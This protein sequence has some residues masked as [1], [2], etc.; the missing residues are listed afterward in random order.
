MAKADTS[1]RDQRQDAA[2]QAILKDL[3]KQRLAELAEA[4]F[5]ISIGGAAYNR[6]LQSLGEA[7]EMG[8]VDVEALLRDPKLM[9]DFSTVHIAAG[10]EEM[11]RNWLRAQLRKGVFKQSPESASEL[12]GRMGRSLWTEGKY[13]L[14][15]MGRGVLPVSPQEMRELRQKLFLGRKQVHEWKEVITTVTSLD[16]TDTATWDAIESLRDHDDRQEEAA[17]ALNNRIRYLKPPNMPEGLWHELLKGKAGQLFELMEDPFELLTEEDKTNLRLQ[18]RAAQEWGTALKVAEGTSPGGM[19]P[20]LQ[21]YSEQQQRLSRME[22]GPGRGHGPLLPG[23]MSFNPAISTRPSVRASQFIPEYYNALR[24]RGITE[25]WRNNVDPEFLKKLQFVHWTQDPEQIADAMSGKPD[26][27]GGGWDAEVPYGARLEDDI[28]AH[29]YLKKSPEGFGGPRFQSSI[30]AVGL[31]LEGDV[32]FIGNFD[33]YSAPT[34]TDVEFEG[35]DPEKHHPALQPATSRKT[36]I[37]MGQRRWVSTHPTSAEQFGHSPVLPVLDK[38]TFLTTEQKEGEVGGKKASSAGK[39]NEALLGNSEVVGVVIPHEEIRKYYDQ[40]FSQ[41]GVAR[42]M[43][44]EA[45]K[46]AERFDVPLLGLDKKPLPL[47]EEW[48][49]T[50][51]PTDKLASKLVKVLRR[52]LWQPKH[53]LGSD[54]APLKEIEEALKVAHLQQDYQAVASFVKGETISPRAN[55]ALKA[56]RIAILDSP[57][58]RGSWKM[59]LREHEDYFRERKVYFPDYWDGEQ[60]ANHLQELLERDGDKALFQ[61]D[62][63]E[64]VDRP[65]WLKKESANR[66]LYGFLKNLQ[67]LRNEVE[68]PKHPDRGYGSLIAMDNSIEDVQNLEAVAA[69]TSRPWKD[70]QREIL[71]TYEGALFVKDNFRGHAYRVAAPWRMPKL[72]HLDEAFQKSVPAIEQHGPIV[73]GIQQYWSKRDNDIKY[74]ADKIGSKPTGLVKQAPAKVV[75]QT[76]AAPPIPRA[77]AALPA[78]EPTALITK[79]VATPKKGAVLEL[80]ETSRGSPLHRAAQLGTPTQGDALR[81]A[82]RGAKIAGATAKT[83]ARW[84]PAALQAAILGY[85][86][87]EVVAEKDPVKRTQLLAGIAPWF[88]PVAGTLGPTLVGQEFTK[89]VPAGPLAMMQMRT[90]GEGSDLTQDRAPT[91]AAP[92]YREG[93]L[94][95]RAQQK[96]RK[97]ADAAIQEITE[98]IQTQAP[99]EDAVEFFEQE[100]QQPIQS[101]WGYLGASDPLHKQRQDAIRKAMAKE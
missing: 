101:G 38:E 63:K 16:A 47:V 78:P 99:D 26:F 74:I 28:S 37:P 80:Y 17:K 88:A 25:A 86:G 81:T 96:K 70:R 77:K 89:L 32:N 24:G 29:A 53:P 46:V 45:A 100:P 5:V 20:R 49:P 92:R 35:G 90:A 51:T 59:A 91:P 41:R 67:P 31:V 8:G 36:G 48:L 15:Q 79:P 54:P 65:E 9:Q 95:A 42:T 68:I 50:N 87:H 27:V 44:Q 18:T 75:P 83:I 14:S 71:R 73:R 7:A 97:E 39:V 76:K 60:W 69:D 98:E 13:Q 82:A 57:A 19:S 84:T 66:T 93:S 56:K 23:E 30:R 10:W 2:K 12:R 1:R 33:I 62:I 4:G 43:A 55:A 58:F 11:E 3:L 64:F 72:A 85:I 94:Q 34:T 52:Q 21:R 61:R 22:T 6:L 40:Y